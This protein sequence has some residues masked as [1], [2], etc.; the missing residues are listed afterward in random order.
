[1]G[2]TEEQRWCRFGTDKVSVQHEVALQSGSGHWRGVLWRRLCIK[3]H[4]VWL[5]AGV[6]ERL[7]VTA[8]FTK[9]NDQQARHSSASPFSTCG[10][11]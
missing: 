11:D 5:L 7:K 4:S 9:L 6:W 3:N 2:R 10:Y 1:M 8:P